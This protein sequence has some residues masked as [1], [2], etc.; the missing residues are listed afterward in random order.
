MQRIILMI[1]IFA[2]MMVF[3]ACSEKKIYISPKYPKLEA[4]QKIPKVD[5][6]ILD[7]I[8]DR[9]DTLKVFKTI[10]ALRVSEE[11]Y[12]RLLG[13]YRGRFINE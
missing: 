1:L 2:L 10:K 4:I 7:G 6:V 13:D 5:I 11:Y 9:N 3:T 12:Y 8:M